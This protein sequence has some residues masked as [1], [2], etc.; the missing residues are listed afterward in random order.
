MKIMTNIQT[1]NV[2]LNHEQ[3]DVFVIIGIFRNSCILCACIL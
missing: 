1:T 2:S 3:K